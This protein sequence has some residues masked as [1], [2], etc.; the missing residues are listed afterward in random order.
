MYANRWKLEAKAFL[1]NELIYTK[2][3]KFL[4][5]QDPRLMTSAERREEE[6]YD[7][8]NLP[9]IMAELP[10][11]IRTKFNLTIRT[12]KQTPSTKKRKAM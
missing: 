11:D 9:Q 2:L 3:D 4:G 5:K 8:N 12:P 6:Y 7:P 10:D 1:R